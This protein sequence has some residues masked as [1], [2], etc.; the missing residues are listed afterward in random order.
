VKQDIRLLDR[1][2]ILLGRV[3]RL[4]YMIVLGW[5]LDIPL[6]RRQQG[7]LAREVR[8]VL[9]FLFS[10]YGGEFIP[11]DH[12]ARPFGYV[13]VTVAIGTLLLRFGRGRGEFGVQVASSSSEAR[14][15]SDWK[16][17]QVVR[18][19]LHDSDDPDLA[20]L[21]DLSDAERLLRTELPSL[22]EATSEG[23]WDLV[24]RKANALF[25]LPMRIR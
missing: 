14:T 2:N 10:E 24:K 7:Q 25:P 22:L 8:D 13:L 15:W 5:W 1:L 18:R 21:R 3:I 19:V 23:Q 9:A 4:T 11:N 20:R 17:L 12:V 16:D 6:E